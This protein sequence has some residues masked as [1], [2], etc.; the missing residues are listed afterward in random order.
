MCGERWMYSRMTGYLFIKGIRRNHPGDCICI[1]SL[2]DL[3]HY[4]SFVMVHMG[5]TGSIW[6]S[7]IHA[8]TS[9][10]DR[11][12]LQSGELIIATTVQRRVVPNQGTSTRPT[13]MGPTPTRTRHSSSS[14][15][16]STENIAQ[17]LENQGDSEVFEF[18]KFREIVNKDPMSTQMPRI[19]HLALYT[20]LHYAC[21]G[22]TRNRST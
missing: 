2:A 6:R 18:F 12:F 3:G 13:L 5:S 19:K 20:P 10:S 9:S 15:S 14:L 11:L 4:D 8:S 1:L 22:K 7:W 16:T 21:I 17:Q